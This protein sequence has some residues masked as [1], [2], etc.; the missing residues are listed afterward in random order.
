MN[1]NN[2]MSKEN[3]GLIWNLLLKNNIFNDIDNDDYPNIVNIFESNF[4]K[5]NN[6]GSEAIEKNKLVI[7]SIINDI[8]SYKE[9][10]N[11]KTI[12]KKKSKVKKEVRFNNKILETPSNKHEENLRNLI[13]KPIDVDILPTKT[14]KDSENE[15]EDEKTKFNNDTNIDTLLSKM[16]KERD[17]DII[18]ISSNTNKDLFW[19]PKVDQ[20]QNLGHPLPQ[21]QTLPQDQ[22]PPQ[23]G[24]LTLTLE[25][26]VNNQQTIFNENKDKN[27]P[28]NEPQNN[29]N[30]E[31]LNKKV[32][33]VQRDIRII[34]SEIIKIKKV[35]H[36][37]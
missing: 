4:N 22:T 16:I 3:K 29:E 11:D 24:S 25:N 23:N 12:N 6:N 37:T 26:N 31:D 21:N 8:N 10:I 14:F 13:N 2:F 18:D 1:E 20:K 27:E 32:V 33:N 19:D 36:I 5:Y 35:L 34:M 7:K 30:V 15:D 17:N 9:N 28:Q